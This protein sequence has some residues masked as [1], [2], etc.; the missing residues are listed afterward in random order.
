MKTSRLAIRVVL[1]LLLLGAGACNRV[2]RLEVDPP[3]KTIYNLGGTAKLLPKGFDKKGNPVEAPKVNWTI[4][5]EKIA[6]ISPTGEVTAVA[7]GETKV[8][9][10]SGAARVEVPIKVL[11]LSSIKVAP[12]KA[13]LV[14]PVGATI[15]FIATPT[16][17]KGLPVDE[18]VKWTSTA[19]AVASVGADGV[20]TAKGSGSVKVVASVEGV[21]GEAA[22]YVDIREI[23]RVA[24]HPEQ[25]I[26]RI[27]ETQTFAATVF[28]V[29]SLAIPNPA[30]NWVSSDKRIATVDQN[31]QVK[32]LAKGTCTIEASFSGKTAVSQIIVN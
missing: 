23:A 27:N 12:E 20:V 28:D 32:A 21:K 6:K 26:L 14:G 25:T 31:G 19:P 16:D 15:L 3:K 24:V 9:A 2:A 17:D 8:T 7:P 30:V 5:D 22:V 10:E 29:N 1:P 4:A 13:L 18:K 11:P